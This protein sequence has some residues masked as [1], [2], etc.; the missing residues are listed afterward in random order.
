MVTG[1]VFDIKK[2]AINDGPGIR[3]AVFLKGCP[4]NCAWCHNPES[5]SPKVEKM[6]NPDKCIGCQYCIESCPEDAC[7]LTPD[8][9]VTDRN[10]CTG[11]GECAKICPTQAAE[12]S[13][14]VVTVVDIAE[15]A[16]KERLFFDQS[17]GGVTI[18]GGEPLLQ[19]EFLKALLDELGARSIHRAVDTTGFAPSE[20]MLDVA[21][22][23]DLFLYDLKMMDSN[24][25]KKWTGVGN[26]KI[27]H[28]LRLL[29]ETEAEIHI[30]IP[31]IRG[32]NDDID[33]IERTAAFISSL[34]GGSAKTINLLPYH[35]I[36]VNK[37]KKLGRYYNPGEISEPG[38]EDLSAIVEIFSKYGLSA[39]VGG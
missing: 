23:T 21:G 33:N 12:M 18:S 39:T 1:L 17:G 35:N 25:H 8:G 16:E 19:P 10:L 20:L 32:V 4:L 27:L 31:L 14:R 34:K 5:I 22:R 29:S 3:V 7:F 37:Y 26:E 11:C 13:G 2:Y 36:M 38:N 28:N 15:I 9:I 24:R 30:R 6:Y